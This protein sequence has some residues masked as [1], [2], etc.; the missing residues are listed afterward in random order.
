M[1]APLELPLRRGRLLALAV[2]SS[3]FLAGAVW[4]T[5]RIGLPSLDFTQNR[6]A[7]EALR[8]IGLLSMAFFGWGSVVLLDLALRPGPGLVIDD[9]G[10]VERTSGLAA[11]RVRWEEIARVR[12][13]PA[14]DGDV[15]VGLDLHHLEAHLDR[16]PGWRRW[17]VRSNVKTGWPHVAI[18]VRAIGQDAHALAALLVAERTRRTGLPPLEGEDAFG[19]G[20]GAPGAPPSGEGRA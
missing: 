1:S 2:V 4:F 12:L 17:L 8:A 14:G 13:A 19:R 10:I 9:E 20:P 5:A 18:H 11:G 16:L 15:V 6:L 3:F 7:D